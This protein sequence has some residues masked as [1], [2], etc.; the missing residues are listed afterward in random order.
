MLVG[1]F[2]DRGDSGSPARLRGIPE[3]LLK[4]LVGFID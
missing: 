1:S 3:E 2:L 4:E